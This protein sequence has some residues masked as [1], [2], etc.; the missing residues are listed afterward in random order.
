MFLDCL[1]RNTSMNK[2]LLIEKIKNLTKAYYKMPIGERDIF[3]L[4][5]I[6]NLINKYL[7][8]HPKDIDTRL[9]LVML[10]YTSNEDPE[11]LVKYLNAAFKYD[12]NN[13]Y[14]TLILADVESFFWG[15]NNGFAI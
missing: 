3:P 4:E 1:L 13:I 12:P 5:E 11:S 9:R 10:E 15:G 6:K 14:A 8:K 7:A 2:E